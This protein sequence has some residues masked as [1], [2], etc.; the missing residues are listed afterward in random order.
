[1]QIRRELS[2]AYPSILI[3]IAAASRIPRLDDSIAEMFSFRQTQTAFVIR[4]M[5]ENGYN[6]FDAELPVLGEPWMVPFEFPL[7]QMIAASLANLFNVDPGYAGRLTSTIFFLLSAIGIYLF[8]SNVFGRQIARL[9]LPV[10]L[11]T[12]FAFQ[13]GSSS[14]IEWLPVC[15]GVWALYIVSFID[16]ASSNT[17]KAWIIL[18]SAFLISISALSKSTTGAIWMASIYLFVTLAIAAKSPFTRD[19]V[20]LLLGIGIVYS[21]ALAPSVLWNSYADQ[22]KARNPFTAWLTSQNLKEWNFGTFS[23]RIDLTNWK[24]IYDR[25]DQ[26]VIGI[27]IAFVAISIFISISREIHSRNFRWIVLSSL[28]GP[29][30][31]FNLYIVHDYY[32]VAIYPFLVLALAVA[33][34]STVRKLGSPNNAFRLLIT[35]VT[36]VIFSTFISPLGSSYMKNY[37]LM[38]TT[39]DISSIIARN[40]EPNE[41]VIM[42]GCDWDPTYLYFADRKGLM[43][44][45][46]RYDQNAV[47]KEAWKEYE[48]IYL[49][50]GTLEGNLPDGMEYVSL[51]G[52]LSKITKYP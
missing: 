15:C 13:W 34:E 32:L 9:V 31:F 7:F 42:I 37:N 23:Q 40:T 2:V 41:K 36:I 20:L 44:M 39:P 47:P 46:G 8:A 33:I 48:F 49:C 38:G 43:L 18:A 26:T 4:S 5:S 29:L 51:D 45:K 50:N 1:L 28:L 24:T 17:N 14:L 6:P 35:T 12:P 19:K 25:I 22:I 52:N 3:L 11:F 16:K 30:L 27:T 21:F 10:Y